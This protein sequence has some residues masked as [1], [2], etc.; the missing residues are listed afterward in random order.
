[1]FC[2]KCGKEIHDEAVICVHCGCPIE[3]KAKMV[4]EQKKTVKCGNDYIFHMILGVLGILFLFLEGFCT[5][6][7]VDIYGTNH[8]SESLFSLLE[9]GI[10]D[11]AMFLVPGIIILSILSIAIFECVGSVKRKP[12][13]GLSIG[14]SALALITMVIGSL[15][16]SDGYYSKYISASNLKFSYV[17]TF[18]EFSTLFYLEIIVLVLMLILSVLNTC[19]I[20][21][22]KKSDN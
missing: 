18:D 4:A 21:L 3:T 17:K 8:Y 1:M 7:K 20:Y 13:K 6:T 14:G 19:G 11:L 16:A 9:V 15:I 5:V 2:Q 10:G 12:I 22:L